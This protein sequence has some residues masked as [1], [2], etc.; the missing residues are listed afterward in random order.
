VIDPAAGDTLYEWA[1]EIFPIHRRLTGSGV[2]ATLAYLGERIPSLRI[3]EVPS[4]TKALD[5]TVPDEWELREAFIEDAT[6]QR[7]VDAARHNLHVVGY[8]DP[9]DRVVTLDELQP[10]LHSLPHAPDAIPYINSYYRPAWGFCLSERQ[11]SAL[12]P[13]NYRVRIDSRKFAGSLTYGEAV[14]PGE[15]DRELLFSTYICH[16]SMANDQ[17][18]GMVVLAGLAQWLAARPSTLTVRILFIPEIIGSAVYISRHLPDLRRVIAGLSVACVGD[19]RAYGMMSSREGGTLADRLLSHALKHHAGTFETFPYLWPNRG[20]DERNWCMPGVDLPVASFFRS[21]YGTYPEYH[22]SFDNLDL[23]S[24]EG[25]RGS[26]EVLTKF[27]ALAEA[28][29][30]LLTRTVGEPMLG[31]RGLYPATYTHHAGMERDTALM[32]NLLAYADGRRDLIALADRIEA[33]AQEC[34]PVI[35]RL[36]GAGLIADAGDTSPGA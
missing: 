31:P 11:R 34:L 14:I 32:M 12:Q 33:D 6:G 2:R 23:I 29:R 10:H 28:N 25:L 15:Q 18:S 1:C 19:E 26:L 17:V 16:P 30:I 24:P 35:D 27:V 36:I 3:C 22:T 20:A 4:G 7:I 21:K 8:S 5:W 9:V 13:G